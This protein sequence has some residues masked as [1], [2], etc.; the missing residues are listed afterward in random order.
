MARL[1][2][3]NLDL[4]TWLDNENPGAGSQTVDNTGLNGDKI[5]LDIAIGTEHNANGTHKADKIDGPSLKTTVADGSSIEATGT[6]RKLQVKALGIQNSHINSNVADADSLEKDGT[7]GKLQIKAVKAGKILGVGTGKAVDGAT[8]GLNSS[9]ELE[10]KDN[11]VAAAKIAHDNTRTKLLLVFGVDGATN[12]GVINGVVT[13]ASVG[14]PIERAGCVTAVTVVDTAGVVA[15]DTA[16]Y[17]ASGTNHFAAHSKITFQ[18]DA[19]V[20]IVKINGTGIS[21]PVTAPVG[22]AALVTIEIELD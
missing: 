18:I 17:N 7:S 12:Y 3:T 4:G 20:L 10:V 15:G 21:D 5:K 22:T 2:T 9:N 8:I 16:A 11:G 13:S 6:P 19:S 1:G 14:V